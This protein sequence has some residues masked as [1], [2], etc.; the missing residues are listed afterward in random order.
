[1]VRNLPISFILFAIGGIF[2]E[3]HRKSTRHVRYKRCK[4]CWARSV[5]KRT[6]QNNILSWH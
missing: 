4:W 3:S 6:L 5:S 2:M 1:V